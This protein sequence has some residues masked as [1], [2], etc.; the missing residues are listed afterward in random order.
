M[1]AEVLYDQVFVVV[2]KVCT[3]TDY[4][5]NVPKYKPGPL[6]V[7]LGVGKETVNSKH[8]ISV[9]FTVKVFEVIDGAVPINSTTPFVKVELA[10]VQSVV[11]FVYEKLFTK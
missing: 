11:V 3:Y 1:F 4:P 5:Y 6:V 7:V 2:L 9:G 10:N 8:I